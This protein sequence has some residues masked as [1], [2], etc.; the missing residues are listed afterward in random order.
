MKSK[1][2]TSRAKTAYGLLSEIAKLAL[3]EPKRMSMGFWIDRRVDDDGD[4]WQWRPSRGWPTCGTVGC[5]GGWTETLRAGYASDTL[6]I[7]GDQAEELFQ[8]PDLCAAPNQQTTTH[9]KAVA[10]H[11]AKFQKKYRAQLLAKKVR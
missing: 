10:R 6:G 3:E 4:E 9:A 8:D 7:D 11:I 5:I 1:L 2:P